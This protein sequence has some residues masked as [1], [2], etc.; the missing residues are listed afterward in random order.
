MLALS[1]ERSSLALTAVVLLT[2]LA[3]LALLGRVLAYWTWDGSRR[4]PSRARRPARR[5]DPALD[6][7]VRSF[8][9][10]A[11]ASATPR[12]RRRIA[13]TLLGVAAATR[14]RPGYAIVQLEGREIV[15]VRARR[16]S[17]ARACGSPKSIR[18]TS[19]VDATASARRSPGRRRSRPTKPPFRATTRHRRDHHEA[20]LVA[21]G[22]RRWSPRQRP[23][24]QSGP[25]IA[26]PPRE[27]A[28][29][30]ARPSPIVV[31]LNFVNADIE[32]VVKAMS[33]I[34]GK[35]FVLDPRVKGTVNIVSAKPVPGRSSTTCSSRR[36]ACRA[37]AAV[38]ER[39]IVKI[40][41]EADAK[42]HQ[43]A[44]VR[45]AGGGAR[46]R[47]PDPDAGIHAHS[48]NPPRSSCRCCGRSSRPTTRSRPIRAPTRWSSPTTPTN[49]RRI[50]KIIDSIDKPSG[51]GP[52]VIPLRHAV[53]TRRRAHR[54]PR[55]SRKRSPRRR[56][57]APAS[58]A[59]QRFTRGRRRALEQPA[60]ARGRSVARSARLRSLVAMLD[61]PTSA[62]GNIH[63]VY[64]KNAD[65]VKLAETLRGDLS[66]EAPPGGHAR[67]LQAP[68]ARRRRRPA[69]LPRRRFAAT[70]P[71]PALLG[72]GSWRPP[73]RAS[74]RRTPRPTRSSSPR[75]TR[76]TTNLRAAIDKLDVRR[77]QV[78]V[79]ALIA[80]VTA[81]KA[82]EFGI[83]W[84]DLS[85]LAAP[86]LDARLRR[87]ELRHARP[88]HPRHR[89][90]SARGGPRPQHR[91]HPRP[92]HDSGRSREVLNLGL[93]VR[94]LE[95]R[96]QREHPLHADAAH[97]RQRGSENRHRAERAVH[98]RAVRAVAARRRRR[99][100][101]RR[102]SG[103][104][105]ASRC[106]SG[107]RS[108]K[109]AP[110][111]CRSTR[112]SR[113]CRDYDQSGRR[114]H[115]QALGRIDGAGRRRRDHRDR[116][117][118][119]GR[120]QRRHGEGAGASG[121]CRCWAAL[122][123]YRTRAPQ[124]DEPHGVPAPDGAARRRSAPAR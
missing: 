88:E 123:Q 118:H 71:P 44:D 87:H 113:A 103:A 41:P 60:R 32:G 30:P 8:R 74:S 111:G 61:T 25:P 63:V 57:G 37:Y 42:L 75:P 24:L 119:P 68:D 49:L 38:E 65:A 66:G 93:L 11:A 45:P 92:R 86:E 55:C 20:S 28:L 116:R 51:I 43:S 124:Q 36:C 35:N 4:V 62:G 79:E 112:K 54:Q 89:R 53:G 82:A 2:T 19:C 114:H 14:G 76:S 33:E 120:G 6:I 83:Q 15:V 78:Y 106:G 85:G 50:E 16:G 67:C 69:R 1:P 9:N 91:R 99:R 31:T 90:E 12:R 13:F 18:I 100:R 5:R 101:S 40:V 39:G 26:S 72:A 104:T 77:A 64:L 109:A 29:P 121:T 117:P 34:T 110:C 46:R 56:P 96:H 107:R 47:R 52:V 73:R 97:A 80:E 21:V 59:A 81:D 22:P 102:S 95:T 3:A 115:Q 122:F 27:A 10:G 7:R 70:S 84:Q 58:R 48:T 98:H 23:P 108:P 105:W 17:R 94:A